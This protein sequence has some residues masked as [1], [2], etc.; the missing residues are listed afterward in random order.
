[1]DG[2]I[3]NQYSQEIA[4][5]MDE[6]FENKYCNIDNWDNLGF[7]DLSYDEFIYL[8]EYSIIDD[9]TYLEFAEKINNDLDLHIENINNLVDFIKY[10]FTKHIS[11]QRVFDKF[12]NLRTEYFNTVAHE[13]ISTIE[14]NGDTVGDILTLPENYPDLDIAT[15]DKPFVYINGNIFVGTINQSHGELLNHVLDTDKIDF[16]RP[17][18]T[19]LKKYDVEQVAFGHII[20]NI[21]FIDKSDS[22]SDDDVASVL[23][24]NYPD[25]KKVYSDMSQNEI[26]RLAKIV[27]A[28]NYLQSYIDEYGQDTME[29]AILNAYHYEDDSYIHHCLEELL[30]ADYDVEAQP[31]AWKKI[32]DMTLEQLIKFSTFGDEI[33]IAKSVLNYAGIP[34][35]NDMDLYNFQKEIANYFYDKLFDKYRSFAEPLYNKILLRA[36][37]DMEYFNEHGNTYNNTNDTQDNTPV[38]NFVGGYDKVEQI[39]DLKDLDDDIDDYVE[40]D[41]NIDYD[42]R[43]AAFIYL[44]GKIVEGNNG[45]SHGQILNNYL[46]KSNDNLYPYIDE[47]GNGWIRP[48]EKVVKEL[49]GA[50]AIAFGHLSNNMA[51]IETCENCSPEEVIEAL[52]E[53]Y[54]LDKIYILNAFNEPNLKR[55]AALESELAPYID[56][57]GVDAV[58]TAINNVIDICN[59]VNAYITD[60]IGPAAAE[61]DNYPTDMYD[62]LSQLSAEDYVSDVID[63]MDNDYIAEQ[64]LDAL[65]IEY[66]ADTDAEN[67]LGE[68][69][70][71]YFLTNLADAETDNIQ[72]DI[73]EQIRNLKYKI[74]YFNTHGNTYNN[75]NDTMDNKEPETVEPDT[76]KEVNNTEE[77]LEEDDKVGDYTNISDILDVKTRNS[78]FVYING[79]IIEGDYN[80]SHAQIINNYLQTNGDERLNDDWYR[81]TPNEVKYKTDAEQIAFGHIVDNMAFIETCEN[82]SPEEVVQALEEDYE[83]SKIY[84]YNRSS[85][86]NLKRLAKLY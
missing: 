69:I 76:F 72:E 42:T 55:V 9:A 60:N 36:E 70:K 26:V 48:K 35:D 81:P 78:A 59:E 79:E 57:Y 77:L 21:A 8:N 22:V 2:D 62:R 82:C 45:E 16:Y 65:N 27:T 52:K 68:N 3:C 64:F 20:S 73:D 53:E 32:H 4:Q 12:S 31:A 28:S 41:E 46:S 85:N 7:T 19:S 10:C 13:K 74:R 23:R 39:Q 34:Y 51:F 44:D 67:T 75:T 37:N 50:E 83:F 30:P 56:E 49:T 40:L 14:N 43:E 61:A 84:Y 18:E 54:N 25:I 24:E 11:N 29:N 63:Y 5:E 80:E 38:T 33:E 71:D 15:R 66:D 6:L 47:G 58:N 1:M 17:S 86:A